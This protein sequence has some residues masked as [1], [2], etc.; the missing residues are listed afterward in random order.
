MSE[1]Q[2]RLDRWLWT[3]RFYRTRSQA[4][5]AVTGGHVSVNGARAKPAKALRPGD[6]VEITRATMRMTVV[7]R[8]IART[9]GPA[10]E[11]IL[12]YDETA[13]SFEARQAAAEQRRLAPDPAPRPG[14]RPTKRDRRRYERGR[15]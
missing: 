13:W 1:E 9:R 8:G 5:E 3:A 14:G 15:P 11:A 12:L 6:E 7:V 2:A 10:A 4:A